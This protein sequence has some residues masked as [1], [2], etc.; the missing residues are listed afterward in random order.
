MKILD[1]TLRNWL[2]IIIG[3]GVLSFILF[4]AFK[5]KNKIMKGLLF[6]LFISLISITGYQLGNWKFAIL[7]FAVPSLALA[8][9]LYAWSYE[10]P[11]DPIWDIEFVTKQGKKVV[12]GVQRGVAIFGSAGSGKTVLIYAIFLIHFARAKFAGIIY[13]FKNGELTELALALFKERLKIIALHEPSISVGCN[14]IHPNY[15]NG[16]KDINQ[17]VKVILDNLT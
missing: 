10:K 6:F 17:I 14:P 7:Y 15:I 9:L 4:G 2:I 8:G 13:D 12:R 1:L 16:E 5:L 11:I 3:I